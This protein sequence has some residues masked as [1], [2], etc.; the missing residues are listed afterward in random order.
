VYSS[1][2]DAGLKPKA[3][4]TEEQSDDDALIGLKDECGWLLIIRYYS[5]SKDAIALRPI[6]LT[7]I[8]LCWTLLSSLLAAPAKFGERKGENGKEEETKGKIIVQPASG[9]LTKRK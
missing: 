4:L 9:H 6:A 5:D 8:H 2:C 7:Q 3:G 1:H